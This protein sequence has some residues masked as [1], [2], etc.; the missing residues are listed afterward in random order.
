MSRIFVVGYFA[1]QEAKTTFANMLPQEELYFLESSVRF[2]RATGDMSY[3]PQQLSN[4]SAISIAKQLFKKPVVM[5]EEAKRMYKRDL[6]AHFAKL[7]DPIPS[8]KTERKKVPLLL[9]R[10]LY[11]PYLFKREFKSAKSKYKLGSSFNQFVNLFKAFPAVLKRFDFQN[12]KD[13]DSSIEVRKLLLRWGFITG[14]QNVKVMFESLNVQKDD[15]FLIWGENRSG[16]MLL[17]DLIEEAGAQKRIL[18]YG[19]LPGTVMVNKKGI[20]GASDI[21]NNWQEFS[22]TNVTKVDMQ[23]TQKTLATIE[24][25]DS[26]SRGRTNS[27][28]DLYSVIFKLKDD[29]DRKKIIYVNGVELLSSGHIWNSNF[30]DSNYINPNEFLLNKTLERFP[31]DKFIV[32]YKEHPLSL[33]SS[34]N[35]LVDKNKFPDVLFINMNMKNIFEFSECVVSYP[36]KVVMSSLMWGIPTVVMGDFTIPSSELPHLYDF[37]EFEPKENV[38]KTN[39][40]INEKRKKSVTEVVAKMLNFNLVKYDTEIFE[41]IDVDIEKDKLLKLIKPEQLY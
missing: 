3:L 7:K 12:F 4:S 30:K 40:T 27:M 21:F 1:N 41:E 18:E 33:R 2:Y 8:I 17:E 13:F 23:N 5:D 28:F 9:V 16:Y 38:F 36:S 39:K 20:F 32:V 31:A 14:Y 35:L 29:K 6:V 22:Q 15:M 24:R 10:F 34:R 19:E 11:L 37:D 26:I 25:R